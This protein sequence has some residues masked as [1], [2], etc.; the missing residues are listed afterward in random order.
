[1]VK[2]STDPS[3]ADGPSHETLSATST[4]GNEARHLPQQDTAEPSSAKLTATSTGDEVEATSNTQLRSALSQPMTASTSSSSNP[5]LKDAATGAATTYG[6]RSRNRGGASRPNYAEDRELEAEFDLQSNAKDDESKKTARPSDTRSSIG[7]ETAVQGNT[8]RRGPGAQSDYDS[9]GISTAKDH[10]PGTST[11]SANPAA[12]T[13][14]QQSKKRKAAGQS[15]PTTTNTSTPVIGPLPGS[16][17]TTRRASLAVQ[18]G[19]AYRESNMLSFENCAGH[20]SDGKL[21]ADDG[22]ILSVNGT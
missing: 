18:A 1:M 16:L 8:T 11:F 14:S 19:T 4:M 7:V 10:I 3:D 15:T 17:H 21:V 2:E 12:S 20:L 13:A 5:S 9:N 22:T 6:T